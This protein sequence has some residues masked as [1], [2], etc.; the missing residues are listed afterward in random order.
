M[1]FLIHHLLFK[2]G[3]RDV[4]RYKAQCAERDRVSLQFRRNE[5]IIQRIEQEKRIETQKEVE[6]ENRN[7]D[8]KANQDVE[9]YIKDCK[10]RK[11]LSL[12]YR[13]KEKR[14]H[15]KWEKKQ[16][17]M[18]R[19]ELSREVRYRAIDSR[20]VQLAQ[21]QE[22]ARKAMDALR[23]AGCTFAVNPFGSLLD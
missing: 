20:Y 23:H 1:R 15:T 2:T 5:A 14:N 11:R 22:R 8:D 16:E 7:L 18:K 13:A 6:Q 3:Y 21:E 12:A 19:L 10:R 17:K 4:N 9:E